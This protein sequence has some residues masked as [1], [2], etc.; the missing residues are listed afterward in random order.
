MATKEM[1][2]ITVVPAIIGLLGGFIVSRI[3]E[4]LRFKKE[5]EKFVKTH[6]EDIKTYNDALEAVAA[7]YKKK[8]LNDFQLLMTVIQDAHTMINGIGEPRTDELNGY[9]GIN[10]MRRDCCIC[11]N[12]ACYLADL[13]NK[14][15]P[16][17]KAEMLCVAMQGT[18]K[19]TVFAVRN[20]R[21]VDDEKEKEKNKTQKK[22]SKFFIIIEAMNKKRES[23]HAITAIKING[24]Y[25]YVDPL[26]CGMIGAY[27][28]GKIR[29][30]NSG[31]SDTLFCRL[32][33]VATRVYRRNSITHYS[34]IDWM[35]LWFEKQISFISD[36][37]W[38]RLY[39]KYNVEEQMKANLSF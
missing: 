29:F 23:N 16:K 21:R 15:N 24:D 13:F 28:R 39:H 7:V 14:I 26:N 37:N 8:N 5:K 17:Y 10:V 9:W 33:K 3:R 11:R 1:T 2:L 38:K 12:L 27:R 32:S 19:E 35:R 22:K 34:E 30:F 36:K 25:L 4:K 6:Y 31:E 18:A 20:A